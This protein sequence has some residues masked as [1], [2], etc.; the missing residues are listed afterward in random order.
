MEKN[1]LGQDIFSNTICSATFG[2]KYTSSTLRLEF[3]SALHTQTIFN[4]RYCH[5][6][7]HYKDWYTL[8][9]RQA[10]QNVGHISRLPGNARSNS[11]ISD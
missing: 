5:L 1:T 4:V 9:E 11:K 8:K 7:T 2:I 6:S 3:N 10:F